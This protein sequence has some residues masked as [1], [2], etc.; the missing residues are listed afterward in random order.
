METGCVFFE[1][2]IEIT[3]ICFYTYSLSYSLSVKGVRY[4]LKISIHRQ[5]CNL[6]CVSKYFLINF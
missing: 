5:V 4:N 3:V 6:S 1:V 2:G